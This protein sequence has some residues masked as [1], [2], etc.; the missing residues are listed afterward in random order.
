MNAITSPASNDSNQDSSASSHCAHGHQHH[1]HSHR[2]GRAVMVVALTVAAGFAGGFV[3]KAYA[4]EH[5]PMMSDADRS[6]RMDQHVTRMVKHLAVELDATPEQQ[7]KMIAIAK[8]AAKDLAPIRMKLHEAHQ[9]GIAILGA[10]KIDR[11]ALE[12]LRVEQIAMMDSNSKR[13]AQSLADLAEVLTPAQRQKLAEH[14]KKMGGH[15]GM[16]GGMHRGMHEGGGM[17]GMGGMGGHGGK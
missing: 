12:K 16:R 1:R 15:K 4:Q 2:F 5:K 11:V 9:R 14:M 10:E 17:G 13:F 3:S 7:E 6:G 8:S